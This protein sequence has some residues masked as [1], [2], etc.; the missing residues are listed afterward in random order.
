MQ[1]DDI[2]AIQRTYDHVYI[3]PHFDDVAASCG[4]R[5]LNQKHAGQSVLLVTVFSARANQDTRVKNRALQAMLDYDRRR[6]EDIEAMRRLGVDFLWLDF[7]EVLFRRQPPWRRYWL[8]YPQTAA[9]QRLCRQVTVKLNEVCR[10]TRCLEMVLPLG[11]GQH[12]D[13]QILFQ[14]GLSLYQYC[15]CPCSIT[16]Y[17]EMPYVLFPFLRN[18]RLKKIIS[19]EIELR[20]HHRTS[21]RYAQMST[22][23]LVYLLT[24]MPSLGLRPGLLRPW[25]PLGLKCLDFCVRHLVRHSTASF[26]PDQIRP[27]VE[28][29]SA[30]IDQKVAAIS[31]YRSQLSDSSMEPHAIKNWLAAYSHGIGMPT[32]FYGELYWHAI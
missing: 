32:G 22:K 29:I 17:E 21:A 5:I 24:A 25:V 3:S 23:K 7:P 10:Q 4:G 6:L 30:V 16:F 1:H 28:D 14:A 13:H 31:A 8:T 27:A 11:V 26:S 20:Q 15:D 18:Y 19:G 9:N 2:Q 12:V